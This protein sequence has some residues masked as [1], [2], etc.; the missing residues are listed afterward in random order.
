MPLAD[1]TPFVLA[2]EDPAHAGFF[3]T[4]NACPEPPT[5]QQ[6]PC[7]R[8]DITGAIELLTA[9]EARRLLLLSAQSNMSLATTIRDIA[10]A[11]S[12]RRSSA[13]VDESSLADTFVFDEHQISTYV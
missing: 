12:S 13:Q 10:F 6:A 8:T 4:A 3:D 2:A 11:R 5:Q 1:I 9:D 7:L